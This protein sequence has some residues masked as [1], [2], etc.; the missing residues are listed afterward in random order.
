MRWH[1]VAPRRCNQDETKGTNRSDQRDNEG[2]RQRPQFSGGTSNLTRVIPKRPR[3]Y[4][5]AEGSP[6]VHGVV[7]GDP[8]LPE[9][10]LRS[11]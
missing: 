10:R 8:S 11:G 9:E 1:S 5:R 4:Q 7:A 2:H 3:S 6:M